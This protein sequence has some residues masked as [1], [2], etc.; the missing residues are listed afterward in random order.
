MAEDYRGW[1]LGHFVPE[2]DVDLHSRDV[3]IK[4]G[5]HRRGE[6]RAEWSP[7]SEARTVTLL[8]RGRF[9]VLFHD[10]EILLEREGDFAYFGPGVAHSFRCDEDSLMLTVRWPSGTPDDAQGRS[11]TSR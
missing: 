9:A 3:E 2:S 7:P 11:S 5:V 4:W 8:I 10:H 6:T 1:F